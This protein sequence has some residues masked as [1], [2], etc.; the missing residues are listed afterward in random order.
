MVGHRRV[1][2]LILAVA[3]PLLARAVA[4]RKKPEQPP[5]TMA[6]DQGRLDG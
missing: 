6:P 3:G 5:S 2:V 4:G 1:S